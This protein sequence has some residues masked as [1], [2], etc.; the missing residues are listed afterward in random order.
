M[1]SD[2]QEMA[3]WLDNP[4]KVHQCNFDRACLSAE[5]MLAMQ[6]SAV[7]SGQIALPLANGTDEHALLS[8]PTSPTT[9][10]RLLR[11]KQQGIRAGLIAGSETGA[12]VSIGKVAP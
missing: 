4:Q 12:P 9:R 3:D 5:I 2:I 7:E 1:P 8:K 10:P 11:A 6:R